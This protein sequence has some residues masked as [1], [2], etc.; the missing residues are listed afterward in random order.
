MEKNRE[1]IIC[2][3]LPPY[4]IPYG[5][6]HNESIEDNALVSFWGVGVPKGPCSE[7]EGGK[8]RYL[9]FMHAVT[10]FI[11]FDCSVS[12]PGCYWGAALCKLLSL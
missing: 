3:F 1:N 2:T 9:I 12:K 8:F 7:C 10:P 6:L 4:C 5:L 11:P